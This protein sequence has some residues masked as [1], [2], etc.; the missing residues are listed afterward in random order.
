MIDDLVEGQQ[1][2]VDRHDLHDWPH[3]QHRGTD[4]GPD[5]TLLADRCVEYPGGAEL[6]EQPGGDLVGTLE[7]TDLLADEKYRLVAQ[8]LSAQGVVQR[9]PIR[10]HGHDCATGSEMTGSPGSW[11]GALATVVA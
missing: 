9:L 5:E 11:C 7:D 6:G 10:H 4:R 2:E 8:H 1:A 3:A